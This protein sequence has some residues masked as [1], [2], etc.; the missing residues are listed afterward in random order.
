ML[1]NTGHGGR[2]DLRDVIRLT[3]PAHVFPS[4]GD[5]PKLEA[6]INLAVEMGYRKDYNAH[7]LFNGR[8]VTLK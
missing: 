4:H 6:G 5:L 1:H 8:E 2:D 7:I 3:N